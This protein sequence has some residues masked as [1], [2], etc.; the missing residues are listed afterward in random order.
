MQN[1][2]ERLSLLRRENKLSQEALA[3]RLGLSRQAISKWE[4]EE[5][6]PDTEN[7][8]ALSEIYGITLDEL[9]NG[10]NAKDE[11]TGEG[12]LT[13]ITEEGENGLEA[14]EHLDEALPKQN[15][16][17]PEQSGKKKRKP[18][19]EKVKK[20]RL[21]PKTHKALL[22]I[23]VIIIVPLL[24]VLTGVLKGVWNPT[25]LINLL[26]PIYYGF[27]HAFGA[28]SKKSFL[29]RLPVFFITVS[30]FLTMGVIWGKWHPAWTVFFIDLVY[31]WIALFIRSD[32]K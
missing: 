10:E 18:K 8:I 17:V 2:G 24:F 27:A 26:I 6:A 14:N 4:R 16:A 28:R 12:T 13:K 11:L 25:W 1:L 30:A 20:A 23:P 21:F 9:L 7:L 32:K 31:Y 22:K 29:L 19:K 3:E 5:C 15:G